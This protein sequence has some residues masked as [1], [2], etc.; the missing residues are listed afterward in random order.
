MKFFKAPHTFHGVISS[1]YHKWATPL[2]ICT[3]LVNFHLFQLATVKLCGLPFIGMSALSFSRAH[4]GAVFE[5][6]PNIPLAVPL[7][8][9]VLFRNRDGNTYYSP[10][11][12]R[13]GVLTTAQISEGTDVGENLVQALPMLT[14]TVYRSAFKRIRRSEGACFAPYHLPEFWQNWT[15]RIMA[16]HLSTACV[17]P[18][19]QLAH[20]WAQFNK[21]TG[22]THF[23][24]FLR[25]ALWAKLP[26]ASRLIPWMGGQGLCQFHRVSEDHDHA[27]RGCLYHTV[28][29]SFVS[30]A[31]PGPVVDIFGNGE[32]SHATQKGLF[33]WTGA[34][35]HWQLRGSRKQGPQAQPTSPL[36]PPTI[37]QFLHTWTAGLNEWL[38]VQHASI[39]KHLIQAFVKGILSFTSQG[40]FQFSTPSSQEGSQGN[41]RKSAFSSGLKHN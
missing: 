21:V 25:R 20:V 40:S 10:E 31:F 8:H 18:P 12:V 34:Y 7:W 36:P 33:T 30:A 23:I 1:A 11:L 4:R 3:G 17:L 41:K 27:L 6:P 28:I 22:P 15:K 19:R 26:V 13:N 24:D 37:Q 35:A 9:N 39:P 14:K 16:R 29:E 2:G 5:T 38:L 32:Q